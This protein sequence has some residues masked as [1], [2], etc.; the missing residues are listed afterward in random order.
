MAAS[1]DGI[2]EDGT[3]VIEIK[4]PYSIRNDKN[5][6]NLK[7][8]KNGILTKSHKYYLQCQLQMRVTNT[9]ICDLVVW[10]PHDV[11]IIPINYDETYA[12]EC[13]VDI[14]KYYH[15]HRVFCKQ[16]MYHKWN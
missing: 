6:D 3:K 14:E 2:I 11:F 1:P 13:I 15:Y 9:K 7:Y 12:K 8:I 4:C 10:I 5:L 16:Y